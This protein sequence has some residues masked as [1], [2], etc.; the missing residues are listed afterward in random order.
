[1]PLL[2]TLTFL[3]C[4][5]FIYL[6]NLGTNCPDL[7][8]IRIEK[9]TIRDENIAKMLHGLS[10]LEVFLFKTPYAPSETVLESI[11]NNCPLIDSHESESIV[12][13][14]K[15][16]TYFSSKNMSHHSVNNLFFFQRFPV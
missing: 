9:L 6:K 7:R 16:W 3:S 15:R 11:K 2:E 13:V 8:E 4:Q 5:P 10:K 12:N 1:M 14:W